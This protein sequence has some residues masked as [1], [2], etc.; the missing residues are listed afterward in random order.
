MLHAR[1]TH[2]PGHRLIARAGMLLLLAVALLITPSTSAAVRV[3]RADP[4]LVLS[5]REVLRT[6]VIIGTDIA[7]VRQV[8]YIIHVPKGVRVL[9]VIHTSGQLRHKEVVELIDDLPPYHYTTRTV[10]STTQPN[11][12]SIAQTR[13]LARYGSATG[14][15]GQYLTIQIAASTTRKPTRDR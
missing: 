7:N 11:V 8:K 3:C 9:A 10:I 1:A 4:I 14:L 6:N 2:I 15:S 13:V 12:R 5:N